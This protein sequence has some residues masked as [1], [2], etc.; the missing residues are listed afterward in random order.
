MDKN[1]KIKNIAALFV[2]LYLISFFAINWNDV[3]WIFNYRQVYALAD[4]FFN[5][6]PTQASVNN[7]LFYPNHTAD[8]AKANTDSAKVKYINST[9]NNLLE[10]PKLGISV[11]IIFSQSTD[12]SL[13]MKDLDKGVVYYPGSVMPGQVGQIVIL[14]HSAPPNWPKIKNAWAFSQLDNLAPG[15]KILVYIDYKQYTYTVKQKNILNRGQDITPLSL[16]Q[17]GNYLALVSCWPPGK[18][19]QRINVQAQVD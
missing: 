8:T 18:D 7:S 12:S 11:D 1:K 5:P 4:N 3:S 19:L 13:I 2:A 16:I 17:G 15:D 9:K 10:I 6:Y 14:G